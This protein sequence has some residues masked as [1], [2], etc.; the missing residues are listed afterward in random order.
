MSFVCLLQFRCSSEKS[1]RHVGESGAFLLGKMRAPTSSV[2]LCDNFPLFDA[3][4]TT[5]ECFH[6]LALTDGNSTSSFKIVPVGGCSTGLSW[7]CFQGVFFSLTHPCLIVFLGSPSGTISRN[8]SLSALIGPP[9][10]RASNHG[11]PSAPPGACETSFPSRPLGMLLQ[12]SRSSFLSYSISLCRFRS[13]C[14]PLPPLLTLPIVNSSVRFFRSFLGPCLAHQ[15]GPATILSAL[16]PPLG[17]PVSGLELVV[18]LF[19]QGRCFSIRPTQ[20]LPPPGSLLREFVVFPQTIL[21]LDAIN[22]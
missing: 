7:Q 15:K 6:C 3:V 4:W 20:V 22:L 21:L 13:K 2:F 17:I 5:N 11:R 10:P 19:S 18:F 9:F 8:F 14:S 16:R 1:F 12:S